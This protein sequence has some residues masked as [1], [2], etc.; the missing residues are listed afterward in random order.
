[1]L[2]DETFL[3]RL[4]ASCYP[5]PLNGGMRRVVF[6]CLGLLRGLEIEA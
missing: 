1:M 5:V 3:S 6:K 4:I 2:Y